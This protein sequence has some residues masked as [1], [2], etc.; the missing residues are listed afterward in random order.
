MPKQGSKGA[1][2]SNV[3][4]ALNSDTTKVKEDRQ[5]KGGNRAY[6]RLTVTVTP[7][8]YDALEA[9]LEEL[10]RAGLNANKSGYINDVL[11]KDL[12][13]TE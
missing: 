10:R 11:A 2:G 5:T 13:L 12:G 4:G 8:V 9:K 7:A 1:T 3:V 6:P